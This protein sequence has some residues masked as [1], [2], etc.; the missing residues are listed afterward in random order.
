MTKH[1]DEC[2]DASFCFDPIVSL[3]KC[4][5]CGQIYIETGEITVYPDDENDEQFEM[6]ASKL[7]D[8][9]KEIEDFFKQSQKETLENS[10]KEGMGG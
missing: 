3:N 6:W 8:V 5:D 7:R 10:Q 1:E 2:V 4:D 9:G